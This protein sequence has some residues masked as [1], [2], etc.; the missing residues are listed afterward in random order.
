VTLYDVLSGTV[1]DQELVPNKTTE[2]TVA[3]DIF[4]RN[5]LEGSLVTADAAHTV[6][7]T[8]DSILKKKGTTYLPLKT[9]SLSFSTP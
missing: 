1:L 8:I 6:P 4:E 5:N 9:I 2:V 7:A 3:R